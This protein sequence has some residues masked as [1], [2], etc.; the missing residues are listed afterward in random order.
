M[1]IEELKCFH[2][3]PLEVYDICPECGFCTDPNYGHGLIDGI[4]NIHSTACSHHGDTK[5]MIDGVIQNSFSKK[6]LEE[7]AKNIASSYGYKNIKKAQAI[8]DLRHLIQGNGGYLGLKEAEDLIEKFIFPVKE[9]LDYA[10]TD[11]NK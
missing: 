1:P 2:H 7:W 10:Y 8:K 3:V 4:L 5:Q 6:E 9:E 11:I